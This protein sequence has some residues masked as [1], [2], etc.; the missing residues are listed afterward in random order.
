MKWRELK[1]GDVLIDEEDLYD[2]Y[3]L[4][5]RDGDAVTWLW[6]EKMQ[7]IRDTCLDPGDMLECFSVY[8]G[9][10]QVHKGVSR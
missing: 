4:V 3:I 1:V 2:D 6:L 5:A 8:R 9:R 7:T 10:N